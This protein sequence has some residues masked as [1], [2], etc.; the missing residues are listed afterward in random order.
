MDNDPFVPS[1]YVRVDG[2]AD[3]IQ[4]GDLVWDYK[5]GL[6]KGTLPGDHYHYLVGQ[7]ANFRFVIRLDP[8]ME[9]ERSVEEQKQKA[10]L[11]PSHYGNW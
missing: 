2:Y 5:S 9:L 3:S 7:D 10:K 11:I 1:G 6:F 4:P 8:Q